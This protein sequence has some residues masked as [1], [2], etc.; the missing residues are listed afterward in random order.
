MI[1]FVACLWFSNLIWSFLIISIQFEA[2]ITP[3]IFEITKWVRMDE[4]TSYLL[5]SLDINS[6]THMTLISRSTDSR[7]MYSGGTTYFSK[8]G[9]QTWS[10]HFYALKLFKIHF[11]AINFWKLVSFLF[12][13]HLE[14]VFYVSVGQKV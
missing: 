8:V 9:S 6:Q 11:Y 3:Q 7:C 13:Q 14:K 10:G 2:K 4:V 12:K 5:Y 1:L